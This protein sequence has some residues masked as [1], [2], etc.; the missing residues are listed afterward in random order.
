MGKN[1]FDQ[2]YAVN[3]VKRRKENGHNSFLILFTGLSGS[4]KSTIANH[5]EIELFK[6]GIHTYSLD[7]DNIRMGI[8]NDLGFSEADRNENLRRIAEVSKLMID[9]GMVTLAAFVSPY[10]KSREMIKNIVGSSNYI[11]IYVN[12]S[13]ETC[14]TRDVKG[15]YAK[16]RSGEIKDFTGI[17]SPYEIPDNP[18]GTVNSDNMTLDEAVQIVLQIVEKKLT[19]EL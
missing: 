9:A 18:D 19:L 17:S 13:I 1:V 15:L 12:T 2:S 10:K 14:E 7:G 3:K 6:K 8:C 16:A 5:V 11:E 4:G